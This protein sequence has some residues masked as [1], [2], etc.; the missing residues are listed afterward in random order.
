MSQSGSRWAIAWLLRDRAAGDCAPDSAWAGRR[1]S[2]PF[3]GAHAMPA[4]ISGR[5]ART[6][7]QALHKTALWRAGSLNGRASATWRRSRK[8]RAG[9]ASG[10]APSSLR[11]G[12][13]PKLALV[14]LTR[15]PTQPSGGSQRANPSFPSASRRVGRP[16]GALPRSRVRRARCSGQRHPPTALG[17]A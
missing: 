10:S 15:T 2:L 13:E 11:A 3:R 4:P 7:S 16:R 12:P 14:R 8:H 17:A 9:P 6:Q 5:R 1:V